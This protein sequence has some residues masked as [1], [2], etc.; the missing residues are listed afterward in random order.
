[1]FYGCGATRRKRRGGKTR[2]NSVFCQFVAGHSPSRRWLLSVAPP[3]IG[4][5]SHSRVSSFAHHPLFRPFPSKRET[6]E[7]GTCPFKRKKRTSNGAVRVQRC[8][9]SCFELCWVLASRSPHHLAGENALSGLAR[10][11]SLSL[12]RLWLFPPLSEEQEQT[13][14][15]VQNRSQVSESTPHR[16]R[17]QREKK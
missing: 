12:A 15:S 13:R 11:L 4:T 6:T 3:K 2:R 16:R 17:G 9:S 8:F 1:M 14:K 7:G 10:S 5:V